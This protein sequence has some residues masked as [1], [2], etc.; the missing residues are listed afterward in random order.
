ERSSVPIG[1][2]FPNSTI[3]ILNENFEYCSPGVQGELYIGG[4]GVSQGYL[5]RPDLT[6]EKFIKLTLEGNEKSIFYRTGDL[7]YLFPDGNICFSGRIDDQTKVMGHRIGL[8]EIENIINSHPSIQK[9]VV[10][11]HPI[12]K[13]E[14]NFLIAFIIYNSNFEI[15]NFISFL[16]KN[17]PF[18]C[19]PNFYLPITSF[20]I[21]HNRKLDRKKL[22]S[23]ILYKNNDFFYFH[24]KYKKKFT[25]TNIEGKKFVK[26]LENIFNIYNLKEIGHYFFYIYNNPLLLIQFLKEIELNCSLKLEPKDTIAIHTIVDLKKFIKKLLLSR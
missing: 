13:S 9:V 10:T 17:I 19:I 16:K 25:V 22:Y 14:E 12:L 24:N 5:N 2:P 6:K 26:I 3:K 7:G 4:H 8:L 15:N 20:P 18:Y 23:Q 11:T 1:R 21:S